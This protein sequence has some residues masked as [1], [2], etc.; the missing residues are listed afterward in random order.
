MIAGLVL[1]GGES[2]RMATPKALLKLGEDTFVD[3]ICNEMKAAGIRLISII[4]GPHHEQ[5][6]EALKSHGEISITHNSQYQKG[7]ISSLQMGLRHLPTGST[8]ALV[9]PVDHPL[10]KTET[11]SLLLSQFKEAKQHLTIPVHDSHRGH[12]VIYD[13]HAIRSVLSFGPDQTAKALQSIYAGQITFVSVEDEGVIKD[14]DTPEDYRK[15][16]GS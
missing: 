1:A 5:I 12:P 2:K 9:W 10:V 13:L 16:V 6:S 7:Q 4:T 3:H 15:Y 11:V 8:A 14:I